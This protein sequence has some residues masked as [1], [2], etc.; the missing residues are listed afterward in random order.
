MTTCYSKIW[1]CLKTTLKIQ[2]AV[3]LYCSVSILTKVAAGF[4]PRHEA[5]ESNIGYLL[6]IAMEWRFLGILVLIFFCL[7]LYAF[8]WQ[9]LIKNAPIAVVYANKSSSILWGQFA[10]VVLFGESLR[11]G[12]LL[13]LL[14]I[15][16]G[17]ML[18]NSSM[19][20]QR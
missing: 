1:D 17:I 14:V 12:N 2:P 19:I 4:L 7:A 11:G 6:K 16:A 18:V 15:L 10:A 5:S 13:G 3:L 9:R 8:I 20:Q